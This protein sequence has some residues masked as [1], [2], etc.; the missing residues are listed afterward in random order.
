MKV[1]LMGGAGNQFF[2]LARAKSLQKQGY[3]VTLVS[4]GKAH[5][6]VY[7]LVGFTIHNQWI[8]LECIAGNLGLPVKTTSLSDIFLIGVC[9]FIKKIR[10]NALF[11][12]VIFDIKSGSS[13]KITFPIDVGYFQSKRHIDSKSVEEVALAILNYLQVQPRKIDNEI[14]V[15]VRAGDVAENN[16]LPQRLTEEICTY[17]TV[18]DFRCRLVSNDQDYANKKFSA[19]ANKV[20]LSSA[21]AREDFVLMCS[22]RYLFLSN[23]T[24]AF[25]AGLCAKNCNAT[26][27]FGPENW[28]F[29]DFLAVENFP[30][31]DS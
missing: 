31:Q 18:N 6:F 15:H 14:T 4:L 16:K 27:V 5:N 17:C 26:K 13:K 20:A 11:N 24:F 9:F 3:N 19:L 28:D 22:A 10:L 12:R 21:S 1:L 23:S 8:D 7:K 29:N 30:R 2:Q 25:W